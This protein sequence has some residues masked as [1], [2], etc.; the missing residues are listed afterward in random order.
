[1]F[2]YQST[3]LHVS[4]EVRYYCARGCGRSYNRR[5]NLLRHLKFECG[6]P[7]QFTCSYCGKYFVHKSNLKNHIIV[8]HE[9]SSNSMYV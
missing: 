7:K 8:I 3:N 5:D 6:V 2:A 9:Q 1:M 4:G